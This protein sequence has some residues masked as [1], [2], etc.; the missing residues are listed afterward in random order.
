MIGETRIDGEMLIMNQ[1]GI[2]VDELCLMA[3]LLGVIVD[4][5]K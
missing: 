5:E 3:R 4:D 1:D 2:S